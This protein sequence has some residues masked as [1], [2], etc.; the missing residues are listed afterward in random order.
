MD[1]VTAAIEA[2]KAK[3]VRGQG[4]VAVHVAV[5]AAAL[6]LFVFGKWTPA[7]VLLAANLL[8]Y[9]FV[10]RRAVDG[11]AQAATEANLRFGLCA[12]LEDVAY[13]PKGGMTQ[14]D[15]G[16]WAMLPMEG[17]GNGLLCRHF[18][19]GR[20]KGMDLACGEVTFHYMVAGA[21]LRERQRF[22]SGTVL[23]ARGK[24]DARRGDWLLLYQDLLDAGVREAFLQ[25]NGYHAAQGAPEGYLLYTHQPDARLPDY[26][27]RRVTRLCREMKRLGALRLTPDGAAAYL[28]LCFYT[29]SA[30]PT[31]R[32]SAAQLRGNTLA[33]RDDLWDLFRFWLTAGKE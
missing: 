27:T 16:Q 1:E 31:T 33:E 8:I 18:V 7:I 2:L 10:V 15:L 30:Y 22:L 5:Y 4:V 6:L 20:G 12:G 28:N 23:T 11:Y 13:Q 19:A 14:A 17:N 32:P 29:G 24:P 21:S 25:S 3:R 9:F 26:L